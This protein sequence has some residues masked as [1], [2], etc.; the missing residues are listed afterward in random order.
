MQLPLHAS[1]HIAFVLNMYQFQQR[2]LN[3]ICQQKL[4]RFYFNTL[5]QYFF[6]NSSNQRKYVEDSQLI[7]LSGKNARR[8]MCLFQV[9]RIK[10][11][12]LRTNIVWTTKTDSLHTILN[13]ALTNDTPRLQVTTGSWNAF[14]HFTFLFLFITFEACRYTNV[15]RK[16][17]EETSKRK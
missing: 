8:G 2:N 17:L 15:P 3:L 4:G 10:S 11:R 7:L 14:I 16:Q 9:R 6:L 5:I 1:E 12:K 13:L